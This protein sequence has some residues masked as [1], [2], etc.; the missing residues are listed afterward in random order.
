M[1]NSFKFKQFDI[2]QVSNPLKVGTDSML[3][4][5]WTAATQKSTSIQ[6][7]LDIGSGTGILA[8]MMAQSFPLSNITAIE[9]DQDSFQEAVLN[10]ANSQFSGQIMSIQSTL[11]QFG[12][13]EKFDL[14]ISNPPYYNGTFISLDDAKNKARHQQELNVSELYEYGA[15]LLTEKGM[16]NVV[17]PITELSEHL[18]RAFDHD[19]F[20]QQILISTKENGEKKRAFLSFGFNDIEPIETTML[21]KNA[22]NQYSN[23]YIELTKD[24]YLKSL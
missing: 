14:I 23:E 4:G 13:I 8:L 22:S 2:I 9:P 1:S 17:I 7:I 11:Q 21:V 16:M 24:F 5:A 6:R 15:D 12:A 3:L 20:L 19:L 10:F 18:E